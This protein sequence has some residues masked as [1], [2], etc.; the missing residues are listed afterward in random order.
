MTFFSHFISISRSENP[1]ITQTV[2]FQ[3]G[4]LNLISPNCSLTLINIELQFD[5][6]NI[7][8]SFIIL[9]NQFFFEMRV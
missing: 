2:Y 5:E 4:T 7:L 3:N 1:N 9:D 8:D 6:M